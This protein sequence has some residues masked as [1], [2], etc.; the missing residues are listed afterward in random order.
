MRSRQLHIVVAVALAT[1]AV[2]VGAAAP[3]SADC[4]FSG[5]STLCSSGGTVRGGSAPPPPTF[6]PYPCTGDPTCMY[7]DNW[8]P[9]IYL[10]LSKAGSSES[11]QSPRKA[12]PAGWR[13]WRGNRPTLTLSG[14]SRHPQPDDNHQ[15]VRTCLLPHNVFGAALTA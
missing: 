6:D 10:D 2:T 3:A 9:N 4:N 11:A 7:Y 15:G 8:D 1:T 5:G 13:R 12:Q 14:R